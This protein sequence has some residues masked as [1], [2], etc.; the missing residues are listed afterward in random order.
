MF[1][2]PAGLVLGRHEGEFEV[3]ALAGAL[4]EMIE[5]YEDSGLFKRGVFPIAAEAV[6]D[7]PL[8][9]PGKITADAG[10]GRLIISDSN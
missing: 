2:G 6:E 5:E 1:I 9:F 4:D 8:S 7:T 10:R 3:D